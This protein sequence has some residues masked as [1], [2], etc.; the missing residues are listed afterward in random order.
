M[1][2]SVFIIRE[3]NRLNENL[4]IYGVYASMEKAISELKEN[5]GDLEFD[6][7]RWI[8]KS[9]RLGYYYRIDEYTVVQ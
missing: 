9:N 8:W 5:E 3:F 7:I 2:K 6:E 1:E 4:Y